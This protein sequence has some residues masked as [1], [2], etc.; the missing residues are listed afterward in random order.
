VVEKPYLSVPVYSVLQAAFANGSRLDGYL[1]CGGSVG[2]GGDW[3]NCPDTVNCSVGDASHAR[4]FGTDATYRKTYSRHL[5]GSNLGFA[6][7]HAKWY[8]SESILAEAPKNTGGGCCR[9]LVSNHLVGLR[10]DN[11]GTQPA[12]GGPMPSGWSGCGF[13]LTPVY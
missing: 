4:L 9:P 8:A 12:N 10:I 6:D 1:G 5:G 7:G 2:G 3:S 11:V 13:V